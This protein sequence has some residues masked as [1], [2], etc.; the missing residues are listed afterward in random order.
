MSRVHHELA[1]AYMPVGEPKALLS[2][3]AMYVELGQYEEACEIYRDMYASVDD[4]RAHY[5]PYVLNNYG[6]NTCARYTPVH[7][8]V[9][10]V[11]FYFSHLGD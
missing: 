11:V 6:T 2:K 10:F 3:A 7:H 4:M 9:V 8:I 1:I 5:Q